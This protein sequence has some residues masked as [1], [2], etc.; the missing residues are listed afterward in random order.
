[1]AKQVDVLRKMLSHRFR[2]IL[3]KFKNSPE[4]LSPQM[5]GAIERFI[6]SEESRADGADPIAYQE[7]LEASQDFDRRKVVG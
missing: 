4:E 5:Y 6:R 3:R 1:M 7:L 2:D